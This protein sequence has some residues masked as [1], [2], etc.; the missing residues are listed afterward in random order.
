MYIFHQLEKTQ[1]GQLNK[2]AQNSSA[3]ER[4]ICLD[5]MGITACWGHCSG[6]K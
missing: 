3:R 6:E 4:V 1:K 2:P 5:Q